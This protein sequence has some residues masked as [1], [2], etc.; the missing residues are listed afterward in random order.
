MRPCRCPLHLKLCTPSGATVL[1]ALAVFAGVF[2]F[3]V[4]RQPDD[5]RPGDAHQQVHRMQAWCRIRKRL[6]KALAQMQELFRGVKAGRK[7]HRLAEL[8]KEI[9]EQQIREVE[10]EGFF[11][12]IGH[13]STPRSLVLTFSRWRCWALACCFAWSS[14]LR[15][16][17]FFSFS[18][19]FAENSRKAAVMTS[20]SRPLKNTR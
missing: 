2:P 4:H 9:H 10:N 13:N 11:P 14:S 20:A 6:R 12:G 8:I 16:E 5:D 15:I 19:F 18:R 7:A 3:G 1:D 17:G